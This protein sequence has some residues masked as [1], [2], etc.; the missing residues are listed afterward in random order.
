MQNPDGAA[1]ATAV[2]HQQHL[3]AQRDT[4]ESLTLLREAVLRLTQQAVRDPP[5]CAPTSHLTKLG[6]DDDVEAYLEVFERTAQRE[7][8]PASPPPSRRART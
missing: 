8:W 1:A 3:Q 7:S 4:A 2:Q 5:T 6:P